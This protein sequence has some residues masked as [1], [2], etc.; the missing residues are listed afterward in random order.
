MTWLIETAER[1]KEL[2]GMI[3]ALWLAW[4]YFADRRSARKQVELDLRRQAYFDFFSAIPAE[5]A[6]LDKFADG[7]DES[8][9]T[10]EEG[11]QALRRLHLLGG[12]KALQCIVTRSAILQR[13]IVELEALKRTARQMTADADPTRWESFRERLRQLR[14]DLDT[15]YRELLVLARRDIG[16]KGGMS[17]IL[18]TLERDEASR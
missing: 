15:N 17:G 6:A 2:E 1:H 16:L 12:R 11:A 9:A 14:T 4:T 5:L 7:D 13:G 8:V 18:S 10:V 3:G